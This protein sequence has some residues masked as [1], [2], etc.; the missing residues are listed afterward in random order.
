MFVFIFSFD[1][2]DVTVI[3][4]TALYTKTITPS[5]YLHFYTIFFRPL[6]IRT[7]TKKSHFF[8]SVKEIKNKRKITFG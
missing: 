4:Y 3:Q 5:H 1:K 2:P 7:M 8:I 6:Q